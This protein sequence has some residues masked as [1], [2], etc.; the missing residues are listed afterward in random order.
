M[1]TP[2]VMA[3]SIVVLIDSVGWI[4]GV[5]PTLKYALDHREL[6]TI[7]RI[8]LL[9][10][11]FE[12][13]GIESLIVAGLIYVVVSALK[14]LASY[15]IWHLRLDGAVLELILLGL[16]ALFWYGFAL[17]FGPVGGVIQVVLLALVWPSLG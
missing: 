17:P 4:A 3:L 16:S 6:P 1:R 12:A 5:L 15:W 10:G 14:L 9:S 8:R 11:P 7:G 2:L 13:L